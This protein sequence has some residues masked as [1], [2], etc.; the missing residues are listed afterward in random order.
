M[1]IVN[2]KRI[3]NIIEPV[4]EL[5]YLY[6]TS[7]LKILSYI[8]GDRL[9]FHC[10]NKEFCCL[11]YLENVKRC[12][13]Q[14]DYLNSENYNIIIITS[15]NSVQFYKLSI[16]H[17]ENHSN[18]AFLLSIEETFCLTEVVSIYDK[19]LHSIEILLYT[20]QK[21]A[22]LL[23]NDSVIIYTFL[24]N[25]KLEKHSLIKIS[26]NFGP[27]S[28]FQICENKLYVLNNK[29]N[30]LSLFSLFTGNKECE[31]DLNLIFSNNESES[32]FKIFL[33]SDNNTIIACSNELKIYQFDLNQKFKID[34]KKSP[35]NVITAF[36]KKMP[37]FTKLTEGIRNTSNKFQQISF[38]QLDLPS[39]LREITCLEDINMTVL[40]EN[41]FVYCQNNKSEFSYLFVM[42]LCGSVVACE[43]FNKK[44]IIITKIGSL[45][46]PFLFLNDN[47]ICT[48]LI[49]ITA[50]KL[51]S[52][53]MFYYCGTVAESISLMNNW[54]DINVKSE[55]LEE[56][57]KNRQL[58]IVA[59]YLKI[60]EEGFNKLWTT[61][62]HNKEWISQ[63][64][65]EFAYWDSIITMLLNCVKESISDTASCQFAEQL[66]QLI[67]CVLTNLI[68]I[69]NLKEKKNNDNED[70][71]LYSKSISEINIKFTKYFK[72]TR[73]LLH[74]D[75]NE[76]LINEFI[77]CNDFTLQE[78]WNK[79]SKMSWLEA[80]QDGIRHDNLLSL[81]G[82]LSQCCQIKDELNQRNLWEIIQQVAMTMAENYISNGN[83]N[84]AIQIFI[85][86]GFS[87]EKKLMDIFK[88]TSNNQL[89]KILASKLEKD[90]L[91]SDKDQ[92]IILFINEL[93]FHYPPFVNEE[94]ENLSLP[95]QISQN[96]ISSNIVIYNWVAYW[97]ENISTR[98]LLAKISDY[99]TSKVSSISPQI[100]WEYMLEYGNLPMLKKWISN[101]FTKKVDKQIFPFGWNINGAMLNN[102][103]LFS[104][105]FIQEF[106]LDSMARIGIFCE[107]EL[108]DFPLLLKRLGRIHFSFGDKIVFLNAS[109]SISVSDFTHRIIHYSLKQNLPNFLY[110]FLTE[111]LYS[112]QSFL[113][114]LFCSTPLL[115]MISSFSNWSKNPDDSNLVFQTILN[116]SQYVYN[117]SEASLQA[118]WKYA[119][120][121]I[122]I[123]TILFT[124]VNLTQF[125]HSM[126]KSL[127]GVDSKF[128]HE[129][130]SSIPLLRDALFK[131]DDG[132]SNM[133]LDVSIYQLLQDNASFDPT[134]LFGWQKTNHIKNEDAMSELPHFSLSSLVETY[135][136]KKK[137][138]FHY[139][140]LN[141]RPSYAY[142]KFIVQEITALGTI[143]TKRI[144][145]ACKEVLQLAIKNYN[146]MKITSACI[147]FTEMLG[148][149]S[150]K[151]RIYIQVALI[152]HKA[153]HLEKDDI[154]I[155]IATLLEISLDNK[156]AAQEFLLILESS[157][158]REIS[159]FGKEKN[160]VVEFI[161]WI[162]IVAFCQ[163]HQLEF[164]TSYM[165]EC[166]Q[167]SDWL[168]FLVFAQ[169]FQIPPML[170]FK[171]LNEFSNQYLIDHLS[172]AFQQRHSALSFFDNETA[173]T[174]VHNIKMKQKNEFRETLYTRI[175]VTKD[176][177]LG[178]SG[179]ATEVSSDDDTNSLISEETISSNEPVLLCSDLWGQI[180][181]CHNSDCPWKSLLQASYLHH[182]PVLSIIAYSYQDAS[183]VQCLATWLHISV[184]EPESNEASTEKNI[185]DLENIMN[186]AIKQGKILLLQK[187]FIL[188]LPNS[189]LLLLIN[190]LVTFMVYKQYESSA[191]YLREFQRHFWNF[192]DKEKEINILNEIKWI[193]RMSVMLLTSSIISC[194]NVYEKILM[195]GHFYFAKIQNMFPS[196]ENVPD[197]NKLYKLLQYVGDLNID[198]NIED[199]LQ[200]EQNDKYKEACTFIIQ[201][202]QQ[203]QQSSDAYMFAKIA[204][205]PLNEILLCQISSETKKFKK[206]LDW[207]DL[208]KRIQYWKQCANMFKIGNIKPEIPAY[209]FKEECDLSNS[210]IEKYILMK[211]AIDWFIKDAPISEDIFKLLN[212]WDVN[213]WLYCIKG[214]VEMK[215]LDIE[216]LIFLEIER[217]YEEYFDF[218]SEN[219]NISYFPLK[220]ET[221]EEILVLEQIIGKLLNVGNL[222]QAQKLNNLFF[223]K[224]K[225][226]NIVKMCLNLAQEIILPTDQDIVSLL[227]GEKK[228]C[229]FPQHKFIGEESLTSY[230]TEHQKEI[231]NI[232]RKLG[233][234]S[235]DATLACK[236]ILIY[237]IAAKVLGQTYDNIKIQ[238]KSFSLIR[239]LL[240]CSYPE[241]HILAKELLTVNSVNIDEITEFL[242]GEIMI[243][244]QI[245]T[246]NT[247]F[248][249]PQSNA[250]LIFNPSNGKSF[251]NLLYLCDDP[252]LLG[253]KL[254]SIVDREIEK[255]LNTWT[256]SNMSLVVEVY[257]RS[258]DCFTATCNM[259][260]ISRILHRARNLARSL[261]EMQEFPILV[262]LLTGI[263]RY[264]EMTY[265]FD[266]LRENR[267]FE[268]L[269]C[270][271]MEKVPNLRLAL[272]DY[273]KRCQ[274]VESEVYSMLALNFS[275]FREIAEI[276]EKSAK[277]SVIKIRKKKT[278]NANVKDDLITTM[279]EFADA[280]ESFS[281]ADCMFHAE[282]CILQAKLIA[283][284]IYLL[285]SGIWIIGLEDKEV[286]KF[287]EEHNKFYETY[288]VAQAYKDRHS[289]N[290][291]I[292]KQVIEKG[293]WE[294]FSE[295][296]AN[297]G[298]SSNLVN[299]ISRRLLLL[300][301]KF[302]SQI[303][304]LKKLIM[305]CDPETKFKVAI[306]FNFKDIIEDLLKSDSGPYIKDFMVIYKRKFAN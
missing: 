110:Y 5:Q 188:F 240:T 46:S 181:I 119:P 49:D 265:I 144:S 84:E 67:V 183:I 53:L 221:E 230:I 202:L 159:L 62:K 173:S 164:I 153:R 200:D 253:M 206:L 244:L 299:D 4:Y 151:L 158:R 154:D 102:V 31:W 59:F 77:E 260:G 45:P 3:P 269:F 42:Q 97:D 211:L 184:E 174:S 41:I 51:I 10:L 143:T 180:L 248:S 303:N 117:M 266:I 192:S 187:G 27:V 71:I 227:S 95:R 226:V 57:L 155:E 19:G 168:K 271:G 98:I 162:P 78:Q 138:T 199:I 288:I 93:D 130:L 232:I 243:C 289:W 242:S 12:T 136:Y 100:C 74:D 172:G 257:I 124:S 190:Y 197:F 160:S 212:E 149:D 302:E 128:L 80:I 163:I 295:F 25:N 55:I 249:I 141:G 70:I 75:E 38:E 107:E 23:N 123:A 207:S 89:R 118:L 210:Y 73:L 283:L 68:N 91:L 133:K 40:R 222:K 109:S 218:H 278:G 272:L 26:D 252:S 94:I 228:T 30:V 182:N 121:E 147:L 85:N 186:I 131:T 217:N 196:V 64:N 14:E 56:G 204:K 82:F 267:Q 219:S 231:I 165:K 139:Y 114:C 145:T 106:I 239:T 166:A 35:K 237:Y 39:N 20:Q 191:E 201:K 294:Y 2:I 215:K 189:L 48:F 277:D 127:I 9:F 235:K 76:V 60:H 111:N 247:E 101:I 304:N 96:L 157:V 22:V 1:P 286:N 108:E 213:L 142:A 113:H 72:T 37:S 273:L 86:M 87:P 50:E 7:D 129:S 270:K 52:E 99:N 140:L 178:S 81:Q 297:I 274:T 13:W 90:K 264:S 152:V 185:N 21:F 233:E 167:A 250:E 34:L 170:V 223:N 156:N 54:Q 224:S 18:C 79:W 287:I 194:E 245:Y 29:R 104:T 301:P 236:R 171:L 296:E 298:L 150:L 251:E 285:P 83:F 6:I 282:E 161:W 225:D 24:S 214:I 103:K 234:I 69:I 66:L 105:N 61:Q 276:L 58:D 44:I 135:G 258:H 65:V 291:A 176:A 122:V 8:Y 115:S 15:S 17:F 255:K 254:L 203:Q 306:E 305:N 195:S 209:F 43:R 281:K 275:M 177:K 280:A 47:N 208:R 112:T 229:Y 148:Q 88:T 259:E 193:E 261:T 36:A 33:T 179:S 220:L 92:Q 279:H 293:N 284:Q 11:K 126:S 246:G 216:D 238:S 120:I 290:Q 134:R 263:G 137:L 125:I 300:N 116:T 198:I 28:Q 205:L 292:F 169:L 268:L 63:I 132:K 32:H 146:I 16:Q 256:K 262:R 175:G 241:K